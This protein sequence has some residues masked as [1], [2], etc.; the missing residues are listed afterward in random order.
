VK[1][2]EHDAVFKL[3]DMDFYA[4]KRERPLSN[5]ISFKGDS[6]TQNIFEGFNKLK[7]NTREIVLAMDAETFGHH[8]K[9]GIELLDQIIQYFNDNGITT[10][11]ISQIV[12]DSFPKEIDEVLKSSW[13]FHDV[14]HETPLD[15][16]NKKGNVVHKVLWE[17]VNGF[18][19]EFKGY[20]THAEVDGLETIP[21]WKEDSLEKVSED[22]KKQIQIKLLLLKSQNSDQ[23]WWA[24]K[25]KVGEK[26]LYDKTLIERN[27][28]N[29]DKILESEPNEKLSK[30]LEKARK[31]VQKE[32][33]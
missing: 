6:S 20:E 30:L 7:N 9:D 10:S 13:S 4:V 23:F 24:S 1:S 14:I 27:F 8:N 28:E 5:L 2:Y 3:K 15:L 33:S 12:D 22:Q 16:W 25:D 31:V 11:T 21:V 17:L 19:K 29:Y 32:F 18:S 26:V